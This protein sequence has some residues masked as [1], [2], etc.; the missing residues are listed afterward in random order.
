MISR[1]VC[2]AVQGTSAE[3]LGMAV[4]LGDYSA[5]GPLVDYL[6]EHNMDWVPFRNG[7]RVLLDLTGKILVGEVTVVGAGWVRLEPAFS[8]VIPILLQHYPTQLSVQSYLI[9]PVTVFLSD[10]R[11]S[12]P[13]A[14]PWAERKVLPLNED[15]RRWLLSL[16]GHEPDVADQITPQNRPAASGTWFGPDVG[17]NMDF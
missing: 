10:V 5:V 13:W 2:K 1:A 11:L 15:C 9:G 12:C 7:D 8:V 6:E 16:Y 3:G 14:F 17:P 4:L